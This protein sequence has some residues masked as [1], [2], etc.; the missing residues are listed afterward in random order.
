MPG[1]TGIPFDQ[2]CRDNKPELLL[3]WHP[4]KNLPLTPDKIASGS[5]K[6]VWWL[7]KCGH[8]WEYILSQRVKGK[9]CPFCFGR[10]V[11]PGF[12]D[13][14]TKR[15]DLMEEWDY[16]KNDENP[17]ILSVGSNLRVWWKCKNGHEWQAT[18]DKRSLSGRGCPVCS[19]KK[20]LEGF[21]DF[22]SKYPELAEE[23]HPTKNGSKKPIDFTCGSNEIIWWKCKNGHEWQSP[24]T[25]RK[26]AKGCPICG[27][28]KVLSGFNDLAS[29]YPELAEEWHP[30]KN[31]SKKPTEFTCGSN[32]MVWWLGKCGH[33]WKTTVAQ[34]AGAKTGCPFCSGRKILS[35]FNDLQTKY[36]E[37]VK[38]LH[39]TKN[40]D[41][42]PSKCSSTSPKKVWWLG[43]CGHTW[44]MS[45]S[46]R[47]LN[48][49]G[50]PYCV[51]ARV[52]EGFN[53]LQTKMPNLAA[54]WHPAKNGTLKP[55]MVTVGCSEKVW[56]LGRCGHEWSTPVDGRA[57]KGN[58]CPYCRNFYALEG[59]N[60][61]TT[62]HPDIAKEWHPTKNG[63]LKPSSVTSGS[64][65]EVWWRD[66]FG[67]EWKT[68]V[69]DRVRADQG[70]PYCR[71]KLLRGFNDLET[72]CP[73]IAKE[74]HPT[75]NGSL[76]PSD[77][78]KNT[79]KKVWW[80]G[81]C[82]HE[83][84][85]Q[86]Y[87]RTAH[88]RGCPYCSTRI[89]PGFND[90]QTKN[91][92][93]AEEWHPIKNGER[94]PC[95]FG[96]G[97][98]T[99]VW[100]LG[101]C[102][103][104]WQA[105][106]N[107]RNRGT[108]CPF[109]SNTRVLP[110]FNDLLTKNSALAAEWHPIKNGALKPD[111][112]LENS[113][114]K[115]W[116][117]G[118]CGHEWQAT[119]DTRARSGCPVCLNRL[120]VPGI[121][122]FLSLEPDLSKEWHPNKNGDLEPGTIKATYDEPVWWLGKC[123]HEWQ[124]TPRARHYYRAGC[125]T[126]F[127][128][129]KTSFNEQALFFYIQKE[130]PDSKSGYWPDFMEGRE[131]DIYIPSLKTAI[132]YDGYAFHKNVK[133]DETK[134]AICAKNNIDLIRI[135]EPGC[136][137]L[138]EQVHCFKVST[139]K[140]EAITEALSYLSV[141]LS[142]KSGR[143]VDLI[144]DVE[145]DRGSVYDLMLTAKKSHSIQ[146][147]KPHL[148]QLWHPTKNGSLKPDMVGFG[149]SRKYWWKGP[150]GHEWQTAPDYLDDTSKCPFCYG[151]RVLSGFN[152][153]ETYR[154][155]LAK[156]WD[157]SKN[158]LKPSEVTKKSNRNVWWICDKGHEWQATIHRRVDN[159]SG[160]PYCSKQKLLPGFNDLATVHPEVAAEWHPTLNGFLQPWEVIDGSKLE[161][162][163]MCEKGHE[164]KVK[165]GS[166]TSMKSI[167][168]ICARHTKN[169]TKTIA[170]TPDLMAQWHPT[171]NKGLDPKIITTGNHTPV[172]WI[173]DKGHEWC[174]PPH[175]RKSGRG[176]PICAG[177]VVLEGYNDLAS[178]Y[179]SVATEWH[180]V[181]N[182]NVHPNQVMA[183]SKKKY[184]WMCKNGH[185]WQ[186]IVSSRTK[187]NTGCPVCFRES[188][189]YKVEE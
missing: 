170:E 179:P 168:P 3:E 107:A 86:V 121:N 71:G 60:D 23:W 50:C 174:I 84:F 188:L 111:H 172:W 63:S 124:E 169:P 140:E 144:P 187:W 136:P 142:K 96:P 146:A 126:C 147:V 17:L 159:N 33:E 104:E 57:V 42:D 7:G 72:S 155:D 22:A 10:K 152:D 148:A 52:L 182:G 145:C 130:F 62:S 122:D 82:G 158:A 180:P 68:K 83:F 14:A 91:P 101:K 16:S 85:T 165:V 143:A 185:E 15:P 128:E 186:A 95:N 131:L 119:P 32:E 88:G 13:L 138:S 118:K 163:W 149:S 132:E 105:T 151:V 11:L 64:N 56:W 4:T 112:I 106:V 30:T 184:W 59:Y 41:F 109:C 45:I 135:R 97:D 21:N 157:Y 6:T 12:N 89:L 51:G 77:V 114:K 134:A 176:C 74:W 150:C 25:E 55:T 44:D 76:K 8:E 175:G 1:K 24:I 36:P 160:C 26:N 94:K 117:L 58:G 189:K 38:E 141:E 46:N 181:K 156:Q 90:F 125:P 139:V 79:Q 108:G 183:G 27:G 177:K 166:R 61:L 127:R 35:G 80:L 53:D 113:S 93:L 75:K 98:P 116:W 103:H 66:N 67:H 40:G 34:R 92:K 20:A 115:V 49:S 70:C 137:E 110:G 133:R 173:C 120:F 167:C 39:P 5:H 81:P 129:S 47:T 153:L 28:R 31:G 73:D 43:R 102:G 171:K 78:T 87:Q 2:W 48:N 29:K 154:P 9:G 69:V 162:W 54:E 161:V 164:W 178:L 37:L 19:G 100:W 65:V 99:K 123:G 18:I